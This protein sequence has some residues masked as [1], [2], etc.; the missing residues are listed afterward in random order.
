MLKDLEKFYEKYFSG[1]GTV[2]MLSIMVVGCPFRKLGV[3]QQEVIADLI[4]QRKNCNNPDAYFSSYKKAEGKIYKPIKGLFF[5]FYACECSR[6]NLNEI[7]STFSYKS[8]CI[9][10]E[11]R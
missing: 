10:Y 8:F 1:T 7:L 4:I 6:E 5:F 11:A 3:P 9:L 2:V